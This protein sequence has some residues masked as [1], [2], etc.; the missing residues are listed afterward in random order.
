MQA[1]VSFISSCRGISSVILSDCEV[2]HIEYSNQW[3]HWT[4]SRCS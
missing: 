2:V 1:P 4:L 3:T